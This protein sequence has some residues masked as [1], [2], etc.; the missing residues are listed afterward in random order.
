ML[1]F[2]QRFFGALALDPATFEE[3]E[4]DRR[5]MA[6]SAAVVVLACLAAGFAAKGL[7]DIGPTSYFIGAVVM[8]FGWLVWVT[9]VSF[10]GT[11]F[12]AEPQTQSD[13]PELLRVMGFAT[14][15]GVFLVFAAMPPLAPAV[16]I[17]VALWMASASVLA[18]RQALD[19]HSVARAFVASSAGWILAVVVMTVIALAMTRTVS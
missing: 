17:I 9:T 8:L 5:A 19:Y 10:V 12:V 7:R 1:R 18:V 4:A 16:F 11:Q 2:V 13:V 14:A 6:Q 3:V 15:P